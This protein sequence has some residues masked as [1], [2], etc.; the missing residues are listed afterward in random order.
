M[1]GSSLVRE[2]VQICANGPK[3]LSV[4][5]DDGDDWSDRNTNH[6]GEFLETRAP[7]E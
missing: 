2:R 3:A 1:Q 6:S 5:G 7:L 4:A